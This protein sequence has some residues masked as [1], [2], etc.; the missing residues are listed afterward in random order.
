MDDERPVEELIGWT[1]WREN[2][3]NGREWFDGANENEPRRRAEVDDLAAWLHAQ[4][5]SGLSIHRRLAPAMDG[6]NWHISGWGNDAPRGSTIR[7]ALI[8]AV[9][10]VATRAP[11]A[12]P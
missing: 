3:P 7:D 2:R 6:M 1:P 10:K 9:R 5:R 11:T 4:G 12:T 8:A